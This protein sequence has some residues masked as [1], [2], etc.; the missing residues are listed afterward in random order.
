MNGN[1]IETDLRLAKEY[2]LKTVWPYIAG[3]KLRGVELFVAQDAFWRLQKVQRDAKDSPVSADAFVDFTKDEFREPEELCRDEDLKPETLAAI[4]APLMPKPTKELT[5]IATISVAHELLMAAKQYIN[6]LPERKT[7]ADRAGEDLVMTFSTVPFVE[8]EASN[9]SDSRQLPL[10]PGVYGKSRELTLPALRKAV[11]SFLEAKGRNRPHIT[12]A[13]WNCQEN[14]TDSLIKSGQLIP[15][16]MGRRQT[17]QEWLQEPT[18]A[19]NDALQNNRIVLH[20]LCE[21]RWLRFKRNLEKQSHAGSQNRR[22][23]RQPRKLR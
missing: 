7:G 16:G 2:W 9:K 3:R 13:E 8:I 15:M 12:E 22:K 6:T 20:D 11:K 10:L 21:L 14:Q 18:E 17:Y 23:T 5:S 1:L 19:L 4:A